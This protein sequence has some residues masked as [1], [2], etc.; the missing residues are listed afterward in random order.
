M[1]CCCGSGSRFNISAKHSYGWDSVM[2]IESWKRAAQLML[3]AS[4]VITVRNIV[5]EFSGALKSFSKN[6]HLLHLL[7]PSKLSEERSSFGLR[8]TFGNPFCTASAP[9][10][11][12]GLV[13]VTIWA[14]FIVIRNNECAGVFGMSIMQRWIRSRR[15]CLFSRIAARSMLPLQRGERGEQLEEVVDTLVAFMCSMSSVA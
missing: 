11:P 12:V 7:P 2:I 6:L 15:V 14:L 3:S 4:G 8:C 13:S 10:A 1:L 5:A 9:S